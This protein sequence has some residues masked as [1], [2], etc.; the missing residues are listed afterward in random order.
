MKH[1]LNKENVTAL[2]IVVIG[3][4]AASMLV[5]V[6]QGVVAKFHKKPTA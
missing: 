2:V 3:V 4:L 1:Y 5:P 6:I